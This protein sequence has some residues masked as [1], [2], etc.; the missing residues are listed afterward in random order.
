MPGTPARAAPELYIAKSVTQSRVS[1]VKRPRRSSIATR[2]DADTECDT[3]YETPIK[4]TTMSRR[5]SLPNKRARRSSI[6][7]NSKMTKAEV[8]LQYSLS[9]L[10]N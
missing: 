10:A 8:F 4:V 6:N 9:K 5:K 1:G 2:R 7:P 3:D